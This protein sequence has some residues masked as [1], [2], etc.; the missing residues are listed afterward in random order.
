M[1]IYMVKVTIAGDYWQL[2]CVQAASDA[3]A[4]KMVGNRLTCRRAQEVKVTRMD[5]DS[6]W[7][8]AHVIMIAQDTGQGSGLEL[9]V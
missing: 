3:E 7:R 2:F 8:S 4:A 5:F 9:F 1:N 6:S